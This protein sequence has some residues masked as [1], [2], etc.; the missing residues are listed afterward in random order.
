MYV[1]GMKAETLNAMFD[2]LASIEKEANI[3]NVMKAFEG[4]KKAPQKTKDLVRK[5]TTNKHVQKAVEYAT[6]PL[7]TADFAHGIANVASR[8]T[9]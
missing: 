8:F 9:G 4:I 2:E 6:N 1:G 3:R 7:N 5:A